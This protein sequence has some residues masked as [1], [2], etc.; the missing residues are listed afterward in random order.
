MRSPLNQP[1]IAQSLDGA[2]PGSLQNPRRANAECA[3]PVPTPSVTSTNYRSS[4]FGGNNVVFP[5]IPPALSVKMRC[6][7]SATHSRVHRELAKTLPTPA[8]GR[9]R[10][11][12][13]GKGKSNDGGLRR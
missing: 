6:F 9:S 4:Q 8:Y 5:D 11:F 3:R 13:S 10:A 1:S 12:D 7:D 2:P